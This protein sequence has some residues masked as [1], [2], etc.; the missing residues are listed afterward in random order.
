MNCTLRSSSHARV[1]LSL[2][3]AA[4]TLA[5]LKCRWNE[6]EESRLIVR[7][8]VPYKSGGLHGPV[9]PY[10]PNAQRGAVPLAG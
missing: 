8:A 2:P 7:V 10:V 4:A 5:L 6:R 9:V 1:A 3:G